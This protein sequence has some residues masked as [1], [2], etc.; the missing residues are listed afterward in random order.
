MAEKI[1]AIDIKKASVVGLAEGGSKDVFPGAVLLVGKGRDIS[2]D[3]ARFLVAGKRAE[4]CDPGL[5]ADRAKEA[6]RLKDEAVKDRADK[7]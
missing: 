4:A 5:K 2:E 6:K 7:K 3:D 1:E